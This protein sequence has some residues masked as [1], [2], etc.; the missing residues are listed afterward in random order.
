M[1][2]K[3]LVLLVDDEPALVELVS[4]LIRA[5]GYD[6]VG[7]ASGEEA[8]SSAEARRPDVILLDIMMPG[9]TGLQTLKLLKQVPSTRH[10]PV[11]ML[12]ALQ[13]GRDIEAAFELGASGYLIKPVAAS[14][15]RRQLDA[16]LKPGTPPSPPLA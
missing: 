2:A 6:A 3:P 9:I 5:F 14:E 4:N 8:L 10:I 15:L 12:T 7:A 11:L 13:G 1:P 16:V